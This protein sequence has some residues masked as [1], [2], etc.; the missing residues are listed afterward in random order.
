MTTGK[1]RAP[2]SARI[3]A[4]TGSTGEDGIPRLGPRR[5]ASSRRGGEPG[6]RRKQGVRTEG[7]CFLRHCLVRQRPELSGAANRS[8]SGQRVGRE[9]T[10]C[11]P[12]A[13]PP[14]GGLAGRQGRLPPPLEGTRRVGGLLGVAGRLSGTVS[15][16]RA[17]QG[18]FLETPW[19]E[20]ASFAK[21]WEPRGF[22]RVAA[23]FSSYDGDLS[24]PLGLALGSPIFPSG[25][26]GKL[27]VALE[28]LQGR[29]D[30][31]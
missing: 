5:Q 6:F 22:S 10:P 19:R 20:R 11:S 17:E 15:P 23:A 13:R 26:E 25:C 28:S 18:T 7:S 4:R 24:L 27:E 14:R 2:G 16:F 12:E 30:L 8:Q 29:R 21:R 3:P 9:P 31:T 1:T